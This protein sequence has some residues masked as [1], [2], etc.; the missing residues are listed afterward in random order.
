MIK[1]HKNFAAIKTEYNAE[2]HP[3]V[4]HIME[5]AGLYLYSCEDF[6][7][8]VEK[9]KEKALK[10][11]KEIQKKYDAFFVRWQQIIQS[12]FPHIDHV[13]P[14]VRHQLAQLAND[15]STLSIVKNYFIRSKEMYSTT[16]NCY[17]IFL[18]E[19]SQL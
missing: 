1:Y 9:L 16:R 19:A 7:R 5:T 8:E 4:S 3:V 15:F 6:D 14:T 11:N 10:C 18:Q 2:I 12:L 13:L 17:A